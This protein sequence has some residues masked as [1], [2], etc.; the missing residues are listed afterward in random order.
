MLDTLNI[1]PVKMR[2]DIGR[3]SSTEGI[4]TTLA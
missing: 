2:I 4:H 1:D 3:S